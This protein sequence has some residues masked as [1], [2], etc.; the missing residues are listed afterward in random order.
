MGS[1]HSPAR[2]PIDY[3]YCSCSLQRLLPDEGFSR[4]LARFRRLSRANSSEEGA[5]TRP[6]AIKERQKACWHAGR[7][8]TVQDS[9]LH[10]GK[11][12]AFFLARERSSGH[13]VV[14]SL[15]HLIEVEA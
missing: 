4:F 5:E 11:Q 15:A 13:Q 12:W 6:L 10:K 9:L 2:L 7:L 14:E 8:E 1:T 3:S